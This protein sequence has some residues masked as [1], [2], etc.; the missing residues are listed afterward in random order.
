[1]IEKRY[2]HLGTV[3]D[4]AE[5]VEFRAEH[6]AKYIR[7]TLGPSPESSGESGPVPEAKSLSRP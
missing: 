6:F 2:G 4:R 7:E 1:M 5:A 3:G